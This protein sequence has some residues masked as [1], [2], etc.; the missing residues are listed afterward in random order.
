MPTQV[1]SIG[2][3]GETSGLTT[4][5]AIASGYVG[6]VINGSTF[7]P[8]LS[9]SRAAVATIA[10]TPGL[11]LIIVSGGATGVTT[12]TRT[13]GE[14]ALGAGGTPVLNAL[15]DLAATPTASNDI[16]YP[17]SAVHNT[18]ANATV[19]FNVICNTSAGSPVGVCS[20]AY[21]VRIA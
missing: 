8:A 3:A 20:L 13:Y 7:S 10:L 5:A 12:G 17:L 14:L 2:K 15:F 16:R 9:G 18:A 11:W 1:K 6:Q 19:Y 4:G 21:A